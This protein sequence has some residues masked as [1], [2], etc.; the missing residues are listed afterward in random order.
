M[1]GCYGSTAEAFD[2][3]VLVKQARLRLEQQRNQIK[4]EGTKL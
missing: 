2:L 4:N 1:G 3:I